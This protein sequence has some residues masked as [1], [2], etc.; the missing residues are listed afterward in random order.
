[1]ILLWLL[2]LIGIP[3]VLG[4]RKRV[5]RLEDEIVRQRQEL[6]TLTEQLRKLRREGIRPP[7]TEDRHSSRRRDENRRHVRPS[8]PH[9]RRLPSTGKPSSA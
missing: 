3:I 1:M 7:E 2:V 6:T 4:L 5:A 8:R 9:R